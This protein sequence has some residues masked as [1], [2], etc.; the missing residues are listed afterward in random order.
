VNVIANPDFDTES[1]DSWLLIG[2]A[3][4]L[5]NGGFASPRS[6]TVTNAGSIHQIVFGIKKKTSGLNEND[7]LKIVSL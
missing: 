7:W 4:I 6:C 3:E 5:S 2:Q 1:G